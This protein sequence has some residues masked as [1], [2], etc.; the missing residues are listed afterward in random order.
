MEALVG[1]MRGQRRADPK[2]VELYI[3]KYEGFMAGLNRVD[4]KTVNPVFC[5]E[6]Q[7]NLNQLHSKALDATEE[8]VLFRPYRD[9]LAKL[10]DLSIHCKDEVEL[11]ASIEN[12]SKKIEN[13]AREVE[14]NDQL[15]QNV[16]AH[17]VIQADIEF[18][19]N[20]QLKVFR[21]K[22]TRIEQQIQHAKNELQNFE[23]KFFSGL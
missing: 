5:Q 4:P 3:K 2:S 7:D 9:I 11:E 12:N 16:E 20:Q 10:C 18:L 8:L 15:L 6:H 22:E 19:K 1:I 17:N 23:A 21:E 13:N 14:Q